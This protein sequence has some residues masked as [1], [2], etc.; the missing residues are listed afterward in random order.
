MKK[1]GKCFLKLLALLLVVQLLPM[2]AF[3]VAAETFDTEITVMGRLVTPDNALDILGDADG[4]AA[5]VRYDYATNTLTLDGANLVRP[6]D[7]SYHDLIKIIS[8]EKTTIKLVGDSTLKYGN[9]IIVSYVID[10]WFFGDLHITGSGTLTYEGGTEYQVAISSGKGNL[11]MDSVTIT[12][13]SICNAN[14]TGLGLINS[15]GDVTLSGTTKIVAESVNLPFGVG[16]HL[17]PGFL[18]V[19]DGAEL[20]LKRNGANWVLDIDGTLDLIDGKI[21]LEKNE[22]FGYGR[23]PLYADYLFITKGELTVFTSPGI[24]DAMNKKPLFTEG[25]DYTIKAGSSADTATVVAENTDYHKKTYVNIVSTYTGVAP[26]YS[27]SITPHDYTFPKRQ[28]GFTT[29]PPAQT[30]TVT[31]TGTAPL[32][33]LSITMNTY[34]H[35]SFNLIANDSRTT[36]GAGLSVTYTVQ[37]KPGIRIIEGD[38][39]GDNF[40]TDVWVHTDRASAAGR[41][42]I[43]LTYD[44]PT[45]NLVVHNDGDDVS[46]S[47]SRPEIGSTVTATADEA[48]NV[49]T[50]EYL[51]F[52]EWRGLDGVKFLNGT[53][54]YSRTVEFEMPEREVTM[55]AVYGVHMDKVVISPK[56]AMVNAGDELAFYVFVDGA[57]DRNTEMEW[58]VIGKGD[59]GTK[60][61][62]GMDGE[63]MVLSVG[64][65]EDKNFTVRVEDLTTGTVYDIAYVYISSTPVVWHDVRVNGGLPKNESYPDSTTLNIAANEPSRGMAFDV[66][67]VAQ[68]DYADFQGDEYD[69]VSQLYID[70][71]TVVTATYK[72]DIYPLGDATLDNVVDLADLLLISSIDNYNKLTTEWN[73]DRFADVNKD[74]KVN[75][76]DLAMARNSKNFNK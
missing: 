69:S 54:K 17:D 15:S 34:D 9:G 46:D 41:V 18:T 37:P 57:T 51:I 10:D 50:P 63:H 71:D 23:A 22:A 45:Y 59:Q 11:T 19:K 25:A 26:R 8:Y 47:T 76:A 52:K 21:T 40:F 16:S 35:E 58:S 61:Y 5:T 44:T 73:V 14:P 68:G 39:G 27:L 7:A 28:T 13:N 66:W 74:G 43:N 75:F 20:S 24:I 38:D 42:D 36:L 62:D 32:N 2:M 70:R 30:F 3:Q 48:I 29:P 56:S 53:N 6:T 31:N 67:N 33:D 64:D 12:A 1:L 60:L 4:A 72:D 49:G 65:R 55:S